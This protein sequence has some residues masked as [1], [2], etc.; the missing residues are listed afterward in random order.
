M[1][2]PPVGTG[3]ASTQQ[4]L[5]QAYADSRQQLQGAGIPSSLTS[6]YKGPGIQHGSVTLAPNGQPPA[7][8][9]LEPTD[10]VPEGAD[11]SIDAHPPEGATPVKDSSTHG[12]GDFW[13]LSSMHD[14]LRDEFKGTHPVD[15]VMSGLAGIGGT[16]AAL[17][18]GANAK[19]ADKVADVVTGRSNHFQAEDAVFDWKKKYIDSAVD[20]WEPKDDDGEAPGGGAEFINNTAK[21]APMIATGGAGFATMIAKSGMDTATQAIDEGKSAKEAMQLGAVDALTT[22]AFAAVSK[23]GGGATFAKRV[24]K[25]IPAG[26]VAQFVGDFVKKAILTHNGH[27]EEA[28]KID[29]LS[30]Q[31]QSAITNSMFAMLP[32]GGKDKATTGAGTPDPNAPPMPDA[33]AVPPQGAQP[34]TFAGGGKTSEGA[35]VSPIDP[36]VTVPGAGAKGR[37]ATPG[38]SLA[39]TPPVAGEPQSAVT[40]AKVPEPVGGT[41]A[42]AAVPAKV[43]DQPS[44]EPQKDYAAQWKD[45]NA[46]LTPR[47]GVLIPKGATNTGIEKGIEQAKSQGRTL[48]LPQGTLVLKNKGEYLK[49]RRD[50]DNSGDTQAVIGKATGAGFGKTPEQTAVVQGH[51][52]D[53]AVAKESMVKPEEVP[54]AVAAVKAEGKIP[55]VTTPEAAI[56]R[57]QD[58]IAGQMPEGAE[59]VAKTEPAPVADANV[60][61]HTEPEASDEEPKQQRALVD[62]PAG[63][64]AVLIAG[65]AK[66]GKVPVRLLDSDGEPT[67]QIINVPQEKLVRGASMSGEP[68]AEKP[69]QAADVTLK[70]R[71]EPE[72]TETPA[73]E[74]TPQAADE[75]QTVAGP[76][77]ELATARDQFKQQEVPAKGRKNPGS[78]K[79]RAGNVATFARALKATAERMTGKAPVADIQHA[80]ATAKKAER[81]DLKSDEAI[82]KGQGVGHTELATH[83]ENLTNAAEKLINPDH[84]LPEPKVS[85]QVKLKAKVAAAK[86]APRAEKPSLSDKI[87]DRNA[88]RDAPH[89]DPAAEKAAYQKYWKTLEARGESKAAIR[90]EIDKILQDRAKRRPSAMT[91]EQ[92]EAFN[93]RVLDKEGIKEKT[94]IKDVPDETKPKVVTKGDELK[95][96]GAGERLMRADDADLD[97]HIGEID[98]LI[99]DI[100]GKAY[101]KADRG[102]FIKSMLEMRA[103]RKGG[104]KG[105]AARDAEI[106]KEMNDYREDHGD[107]DDSG[108]HEARILGSHEVS[109]ELAQLHANLEKSGAYPSMREAAKAGQEFSAQ[110]ALDHMAGQTPE[111]PLRDFLRKLSAHTPAATM[112]R[113][114]HEITNHRTGEKMGGAGLFER[115]HNLIQVKVGGPD[116]RLTHAIIHEATHAATVHLASREPN[117]PFVREAKRLRQVFENRLRARLGDGVIQAHLDYHNGGTQPFDLINNLYGLKNHLEF[118]AEAVSNPKFQQ[119]IAES[120]AYKQTDEGFLGGAHKLADA[121]VGAIK[122]ALGIFKPAE[123][124]LLHAVLRNAED[125]MEAQKLNLEGPEAA[126][127]MA[128]LHSLNE[129]EPKALRGVDRPLRRLVGD[130]IAGKARDFYRSIQKGAPHAMRRL[131]LWNE[132]HDQITRSNAHWFGRDDN[133]NPMRQYDDIK[134]RQVAI[135]N[136]ALARSADIVKTRQRL[137]RAEDRSLGELQRDA[138]QFGI[139]PSLPKDQQSQISKSDKGFDARYDEYQRRWNKLSPKAQSV[140]TGERDANKWMANQIRKKGVDLALQSFGDKP[141][142]DAQKSLLY[143]IRNKA[144]YSD[145][146]GQGKSIDVGEHNDKLTKALE[147]MAAVGHQ[148]GPYFHLGRNGEYVVQVHPEGE[149]EFG[150]QAEAEAYA[151]KVREFGPTSK[152]KVVERG[153]KWVADYKANYVSMHENADQAETER[154]NLQKQGHEVPTVTSKIEAA[155]GGALTKGI[156]S[157]V[158]EVSRKLERKGGGADTKALADALRSTFVQMMAQRSAYASSKLARRGFGGVKGEEMGRNFASH[159]QSMAWHLSH[160]STVMEQGEALGR[161]RELSKTDPSAS[162]KTMYKRGAVMR[163]MSKRTAQEVSQFGIKNPSNAISAKLGFANF[164]ASPGHLIV[165]STQNWTT[166]LPIAGPKWGY[167]RSA[168]AFGRAHNAVFGSTAMATYKALKPGAFT[169][170]DMF[171]HV[172]DAVAKHPTLG[173]WARG[174]NAAL[175][176]LMDRGIISNSFANE[177][178]NIGKQGVNS[179]LQRTYDYGRILPQIAEVYNRISTALVGLEMTKGDLTKTA[180]FVRESHV[181]YSQSNKTRAG[182]LLAKV[183]FGNTVTMFH[184]YIQGMRHLLYSNVKN[185]VYA[186]TKSRAEAAK[187]VAGLIV[188]QSIFAGVVKGAGLEPLRGIAYLWHQ[189]FGDD[190]EYHSFDNSVRHFISDAVGNKTA[191]DAI[192]GG[193]PHLLGFDLSGRMGLSDLFLHD[194]PDLLHADSKELM[195]FLGQQLGGPMGEMVGQEKD[196]MMSAYDRGDPFGMIMAM[197]P[198]KALRD[199]MDAYELLTKGKQSRGG[200]VTQPSAVDALYRAAGLKPADVARVQERQG[201][202]AQYTQFAANRKA[203]LMKAFTGTEGD[204]QDSVYDRVQNYNDANPGKALSVHDFM[205]A[206]RSG[207]LAENTAEGG[208][209]KDPKIDELL[210]Y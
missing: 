68:P 103:E 209:E 76:L 145:H 33:E 112:L 4:L 61:Q 46:A 87:A 199:G 73:K 3:D 122:R 19:I 94:T 190:D 93:K 129:E 38:E 5:D 167:G 172:L 98:K 82:S 95:L 185:M 195:Q 132:T 7:S 71:G 35:P 181:D 115:D 74:A 45:M 83:A 72:V 151:A 200:T 186:E 130:T 141:I 166:A 41:A 52:P 53:G 118:M 160:M 163:E 175:R 64:K 47:V 152:A 161:I 28:D 30:S 150:T 104:L 124:K 169:A 12:N 63:Q 16:A 6:A 56:Q 205:R 144:E 116:S 193:L 62:T 123:A 29:L 27:Q 42:R 99:D 204:A 22:A 113:P 108:E 155:E 168:A 142:S 125:V 81:L 149:K 20:S 135:Q 164:L 180:D 50:L 156:E 119:L 36:S 111:G 136:K 75:K 201:E 39:A 79:D 60:T 173:K 65:E 8:A 44:P 89:D 131:I 170:E 109:P 32:H 174:E 48:E 18:G 137:D 179:A 206:E 178:G 198:I 15:A 11:Y 157:M 188:A 176:Q 143:S 24:V 128:A 134:Q 153:G 120:E 54:A 10:T 183:P 187:T 162:Q 165:N 34:V 127:D 70:P 23:Y 106:E 114:V 86:E 26:A 66:D 9:P 139:D 191:A 147:D 171:H 121:V 196:A 88:L 140:F 97:A 91:P 110:G 67:D 117:H 37:F 58:E 55:V 13:S 43:P 84:V 138:T 31:L 177:L 96:K 85:K 159:T 92:A 17:V 21:I 154:E 105:R 107:S 57:R 100:Y 184:T 2:A 197:M 80:I 40:P 146:I 192:S 101:S 208:P 1:A 69:A 158:G 25:Q 210:D 133:T 77:G 126:H 59:P 203:R 14:F 182:K 148:S 51:T 194:P 189:L 207:Q 202:V 78:V 102:E 90:E 49:A